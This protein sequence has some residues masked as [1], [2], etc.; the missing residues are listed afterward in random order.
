MKLQWTKHTP[1]C[2]FTSK[3]DVSPFFHDFKLAI[4]RAKRVPPSIIPNLMAWMLPVNINDRKPPTERSAP[5]E[6]EQFLDITTS[7]N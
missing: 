3:D 6:T 1:V 2:P 4:L 7:H 5:D